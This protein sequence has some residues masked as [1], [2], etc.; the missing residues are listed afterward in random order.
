MGR[1]GGP[2][3]ET[4]QDFQEIVLRVCGQCVPPRVHADAGTAGDAVVEAHVGG[5]RLVKLHVPV[6]V[7]RYLLTEL[8]SEADLGE[9]RAVRRERPRRES[10]RTCGSQVVNQDSR[11]VCM[12]ILHRF[13]SGNASPDC[14]ISNL[15][16]IN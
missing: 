3:F 7:R 9:S 13:L 5:L 15:G 6:A 16:V 2:R 14:N 10:T 8:L 4:A 12:W 1:P 11:Y